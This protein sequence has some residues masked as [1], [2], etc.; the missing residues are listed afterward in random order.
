LTYFTS[1]FMQDPVF[2]YEGTG[3]EDVMG[4]LLMSHIVQKHVRHYAMGLNFHT[5]W[6]DMFAY[7]IGICHAMWDQEFAKRTI[8]R[9]VGWVDTLKK[10]FF[11]T[12]EERAESDYEVVFEGNKLENIDPYSFFMDPNVTAHEIEKAEYVGWIDETSLHSLLL[13]EKRRS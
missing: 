5:A 3:P 2:E 12:G 1:A 6:R 8:R 7:G 11:P 9:E 13:Q 4:S 10:K